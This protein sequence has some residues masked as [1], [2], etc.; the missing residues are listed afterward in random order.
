MLIN[1]QVLTDSG[2]CSLVEPCLFGDTGIEP[3]DLVT[4]GFQKPGICVLEVIGVRSKYFEFIIRGK[5]R[6]KENTYKW[7]SV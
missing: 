6:A 4:I 5:A 1:V 7:V 2:D 3:A